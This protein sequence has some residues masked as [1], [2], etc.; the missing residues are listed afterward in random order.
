MENISE[1]WEALRPQINNTSH[2]IVHVI[3]STAISF[4]RVA[5]YM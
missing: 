3:A 2:G 4:Y 1:I 5:E